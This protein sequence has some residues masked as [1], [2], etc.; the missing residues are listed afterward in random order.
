MKIQNKD[1]KRLLEFADSF[2]M[3]VGNKFFNKNL[4]K[5]MTFKSDGNSFVIDLVV[6]KKEVMKRV[7][8]NAFQYTGSLLLIWHGKINHSKKNL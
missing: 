6:V 1:G 4:E 5:L 3:V 2:D 8:K 7:V